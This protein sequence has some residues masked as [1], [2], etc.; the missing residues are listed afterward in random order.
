MIEDSLRRIVNESTFPHHRHVK[1]KTEPSQETN[2][3]DV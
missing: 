1:N 2:L 3:R